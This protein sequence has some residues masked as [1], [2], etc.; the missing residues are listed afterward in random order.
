MSFRP[1][2][3]EVVGQLSALLGPE[4]CILDADE[5]KRY[6]ADETEDFLFLPEVVVRPATVAEIS[7]VLAFATAHRIPVT[8]RGGGTGLSGGALP[9]HGGILLSMERFNR[10]LSID[11]EN[12]QAV[13]EPG[14]ITQKLHEEVESI[15][16]YYPPDPA[17]RG[18][19]QIGGNLAE[20]AGG[21]HAVKY[22]VTRDYVLGL[23][24][25]L[26]TGEVMRTGGTS[27]KAPPDTI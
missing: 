1:V 25:V 2:T 22:G 6:G 7:S 20:C 24:A 10:I 3:G 5:R 4:A 21:P 17:S 8:P 26:P 12:L 14:V 27:Q 23:E 15:G 11:R 18:S 16:L 19:C 9:V 13:V